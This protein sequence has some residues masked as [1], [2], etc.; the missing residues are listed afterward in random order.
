VQVLQLYASFYQ[1]ATTNNQELQLVRKYIE[2]EWPKHKK[3]VQNTSLGKYWNVRDE[4][5]I[6]SNLVY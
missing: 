3:D 6:H 4:L 5:Y 2:R 1:R